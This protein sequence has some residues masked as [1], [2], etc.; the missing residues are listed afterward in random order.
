M[1]FG[2]D[3][4]IMDSNITNTI[5]S[6][7][8]ALKSLFISSVYKIILSSFS[9]LVLGPIILQFL[10]IVIEYAITQVFTGF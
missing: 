2:V 7:T 9:S 6:V 1:G 8:L 5:L 3:L 4:S 10:G